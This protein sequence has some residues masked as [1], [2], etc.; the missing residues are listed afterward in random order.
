MSLHFI[1]DGYNLIKQAPHLDKANLEGSRK[2]LISLLSLYQPQGSKRNRVTVVYDGRQGSFF[3]PGSSS[4]VGIIFTQGESADDKI[5][6]MIEKSE[7]PRNIIVVTNDRE[8][9][10]FARQNNA[11]VKTVEDFLAKCDCPKPKVK[12]DDKIIGPLEAAEI[13]EEMKKI[14]LRKN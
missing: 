3:A 2:A 7:N 14:W 5:K 1:I 12:V 11:Q 9:Q 10:R 6:R 8:I 13:N 4:L